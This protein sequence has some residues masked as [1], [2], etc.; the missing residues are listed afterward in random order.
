ML[1]ASVLARAAS[2]NTLFA[3]HSAMEIGC[4]AQRNKNCHNRDQNKRNGCQVA[5]HTVLRA[6]SSMLTLSLR[7][8]TDVS[9][10]LYGNFPDSLRVGDHGLA[11]SKRG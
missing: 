2:K 4:L 3:H 10:W 1:G 9:S 8:P 6:N 11:A 7:L 5:F